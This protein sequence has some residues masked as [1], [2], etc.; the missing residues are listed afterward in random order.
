MIINNG[1]IFCSDYV[2][3]IKKIMKLMQL[4]FPMFRK[5][6]VELTQE[7]EIESIPDRPSRSF[8]AVTKLFSQTFKLNNL[9][10]G[11]QD[12]CLHCHYYYSCWKYFSQGWGFAFYSGGGPATRFRDF[13]S[14]FREKCC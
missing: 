3:F 4:S 1:L 11:Q 9:K 6:E 10:L 14:F 12:S 8:S 13:N 5:I 2:G 7:K